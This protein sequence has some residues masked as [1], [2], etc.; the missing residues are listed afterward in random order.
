MRKKKSLILIGI[1]VVLILVTVPI[2]ATKPENYIAHG[3]IDSYADAYSSQIVG[4]NW[5][6]Q[7][8]D[9]KI[10][11]RYEY[12]EENIDPSVENSPEGSVDFFI[13]TFTVD[14]YVL[15]GDTLVFT[16]TKH[17]KKVWVKLD[18]TRE[19]VQWDRYPVTVTIDSNGIIID[20]PP[21]AGQNFDTLGTTLFIKYNS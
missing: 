9:D 1:V 7:L 13:N 21:A 2:Y 6:V 5:I 3:T 12:F 14:G 8:V 15:T 18:R 17:V 10:Y 20:L 19:L 4:G 11:F 16:G